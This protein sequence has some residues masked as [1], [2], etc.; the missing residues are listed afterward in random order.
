MAP[1]SQTFFKARDKRAPYIIR[2]RAQQR[3]K[4]GEEEEEEENGGGSNKSKVGA[5]SGR[6]DERERVHELM[7]PGVYISIISRPNKSQR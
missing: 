2:E 4:K 5:R 3:E 7:S 6:R 1:S